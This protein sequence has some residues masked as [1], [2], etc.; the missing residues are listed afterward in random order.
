M[1]EEERRKQNAAID[2]KIPQQPVTY[3][4][5]T[6]GYYSRIDHILQ[7]ALDRHADVRE[8]VLNQG[9]IH[10]DIKFDGRPMGNAILGYMIPTLF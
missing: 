6:V 9:T 5:S 4:D 1:I 8:R 3:G 2:L 7:V 10:L